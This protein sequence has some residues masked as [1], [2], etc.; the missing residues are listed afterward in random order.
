MNQSIDIN[1]YKYS[2]YGIG[3]DINGFFSVGNWVDKN[4]VIFGL[5]MCLSTK[6]GNREKD[7]LV[8]GKGLTQGL[9]HTLSAEKM[10]PIS[11]TENNKSFVWACIIMEQIVWNCDS[12]RFWNCGPSIMSKK[13]FKRLSSR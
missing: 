2:G 5:D 9:E 4:V 10:Y 8:L 1:K 12:A 7:I 6:I 13:H 11:F 3:F